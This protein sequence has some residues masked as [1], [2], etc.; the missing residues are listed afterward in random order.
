MWGYS[1]THFAENHMMFQQ[2]TIYAILKTA[3][4]IVS[5]ARFNLN[6]FLS[7]EDKEVEQ[8]TRTIILFT[9]F[10]GDQHRKWRTTQ[11]CFDVYWFVS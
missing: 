4:K 5:K 2:N 10:K 11:D 3:E 6:S 9:N 7:F 8:H 1:F